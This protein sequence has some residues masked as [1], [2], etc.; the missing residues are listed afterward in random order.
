M[1]HAP[2]IDVICP[3]NVEDEIR[4]APQASAAYPRKRE[5]MPVTRRAGAGMDGDAPIGRLQSIDEPQCR[6]GSGFSNIMFDGFFN[7]PPSRLAR[8]YPFAAHSASAVLTWMAYA[9]DA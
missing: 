5:L 4:K 2:D 3:F 8:D 9:R 6:I 7:I 1:Q